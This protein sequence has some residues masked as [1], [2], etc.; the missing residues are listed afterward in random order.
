MKTLKLI[1]ISIFSL[2]IFAAE[3]P[4]FSSFSCKSWGG[5]KVEGALQECQDARYPD[6]SDGGCFH[7]V[8]TKGSEVLHDVEVLRDVTWRET[9]QG[10]YTLYNYDSEEWIPVGITISLGSEHRF[11]LSKRGATREQMVLVAKGP[12]QLK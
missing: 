9:Q 5:I 11:T 8:V 2:T 12:C 6:W 4:D 1:L 7:M 10:Y 3:G